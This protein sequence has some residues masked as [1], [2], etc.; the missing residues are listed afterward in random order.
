LGR[1]NVEKGVGTLLEACQKLPSAGWNLLIAGKEASEVDNMRGLAAGLPI[2]FLGFVPAR[3]LLDEIDILIVPSIW[4]EPLPRTILEAYAAGVPVIGAN[5]GGIPDLIG[6]DN[7]EWLFPPG[8]AGALAA[9][10]RTAIQR[11]RGALPGGQD[12]Q[13]IVDDTAPSRV[14]LRYAKLYEE[15]QVFMAEKSGIS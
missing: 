2:E 9:A 5:S 10:M 4:A 15:L 12:F 14:A 6:I 8:D 13:H 3:Q 1:I 11:G 7:I